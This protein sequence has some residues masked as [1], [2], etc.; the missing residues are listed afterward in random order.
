MLED[1]IFLDKKEIVNKENIKSY[2]YLPLYII[3]IGRHFL[4]VCLDDHFKY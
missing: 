4:I 2:F 3:L 1:A